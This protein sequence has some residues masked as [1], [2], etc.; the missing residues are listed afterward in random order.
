M[1]YSHYLDTENTKPL[2]VKKWNQFLKLVKQVVAEHKDVLTGWDGDI[3]TPITL[4]KDEISFNGIG[5]NSHES[6]NIT[7]K[8]DSFTFCKTAH[9]PYDE[10]TIITYA[11]AGMIF[12]LEFSSDGGEG[13][14]SRANDIAKNMLRLEGLELLKV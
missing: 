14:V 2:P 3:K 11:L 5:D 1:G 7:R 12:G 4:T 10:A 13:E 6:C 8:A 9:K